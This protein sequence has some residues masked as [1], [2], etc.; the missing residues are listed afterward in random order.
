[1]NTNRESTHERRPKVTQERLDGS[2]DG[3]YEAL[4][5]DLWNGYRACSNWEHFDQIGSLEE[6]LPP[7]KELTAEQLV[8]VFFKSNK[9]SE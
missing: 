6:V 3:L 8:E 9:N 1:M 7:I 5:I 4:D 2:S